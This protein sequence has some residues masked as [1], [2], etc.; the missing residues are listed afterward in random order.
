MQVYNIPIDADK[1]ENTRHGDISLPMA[2][3]ETDPKKNILGF[4]NWHWHEE[5]Q[6]M[7]VLKGSVKVRLNTTEFLLNTG[8]GA[9]ELAAL[10][11]ELLDLVLFVGLERAHAGQKLRHAQSSA[12]H[13]GGEVGLAQP[14]RVAQG[15]QPLA[16]RRRF[17][18][19][20]TS[21]SH[22]RSI[23]VI[24]GNPLLWKKCLHGVGQY[25]YHLSP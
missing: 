22:A 9:F 23:R 21:S 11:L 15:C 8:D 1:K 25:S 18:I 14:V 13:L 6:F 10:G 4:V 19:R 17:S 16:E 3:Y 7:R 24:L 5:L 20:W 2:I 12:G